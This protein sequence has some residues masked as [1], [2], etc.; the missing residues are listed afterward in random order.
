M[1]DWIFDVSFYLFLFVLFTISNIILRIKLLSLKSS[2]IKESKSLIHSRN[3]LYEEKESFEKSKRTFEREKEKFEREKKSFDF[4]KAI[5]EKDRQNLNAL[6]RERSVLLAQDVSSRPYLRTTPAFQAISQCDDTMYDRLRPALT[7]SFSISPPFDITAHMI[8]SNG[9]E[10]VTTLHS[11][12]CPDF[13]I[14]KCVCKHMLRLAVESGLLLH[15]SRVSPLKNDIAALLEQRKKF[16]VEKASLAKEKVLFSQKKKSFQKISNETSQKFPWVAKLY[17]DCFEALEIRY[18]DYLETKPHPAHST[19]K[20]MEQAI[21][22]DLSTWRRRAKEYEYQINFYESLFP[23]L[24]SFKE[25]PPSSA[26][27]S[28]SEM[29]TSCDDNAMLRNWISPE[30]YRSLNTSERYQLALDRYISRP[31]SSWDVG[32]EYERYIGYLCEKSG[33]SVYYSGAIK[34]KE[35]MGRDLIIKKSS[36]TVLIQCKRWG[37]E[38]VIHE[39]H[40]FQLAGSVFE[41][42]TMHPDEQVMGAF[43]TTVDFSP[44]AVHCASLLGISL[45]PSIPFQEYPRIKCNVGRNSSGQPI[46]IYHLPMDQQYDRVRISDDGEFYAASV[47][48]AESKGFRRAYRWQGNISSGGK[49]HASRNA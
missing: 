15:E 32:I 33:Y 21:R 4:D 36:Q 47:S 13:Q 11:C 20:R 19:A 14:R 42:Q 40:V 2:L 34:C 44:V 29:E 10:Y 9:A 3:Y 27:E 45:Y 8:S 22:Q 6:V 38:K 1:K 17:S 31:K 28:V 5:F 49:P 46:K 41:Y 48:E 24:T 43:V 23:W 37:K 18:A 35:D 7:P 30:E 16:Q 25:L 39:N 26:F 12:T